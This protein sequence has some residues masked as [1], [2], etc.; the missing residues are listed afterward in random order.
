MTMPS[1]SRVAIVVL[2]AVT[3]VGTQ[4]APRAGA[5]SWWVPPLGS[6]PWQW[7]LSHPLRLSNPQDMG[8]DDKL[9]D[10]KPASP[11]VIYDIDGIINPAS[12]VAALHAEGKHVVCYI[13][14]GAAGNY[15]SAASEGV[16]TTY[17][18]QLRKA[19]VFGNKVSG[20]PEYYLDIRSSATVSIIESMI[21]QQCA[22]KGF[23]AVETDIDEEYGDN[24]GFPLKR[25]NQEQYMTTLADY[26]HG[27][28]L[29]WWIK[30]PDD[31]GSATYAT[32]MHSL[33]DAVLTEQCNQYS[34]CGFLSA[35]QGKKAVFN[36]EYHL[37]PSAFC[38]N[39][40]RLGFNGA[41]FNLNLTGVRKPCQ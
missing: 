37:K 7:E 23:D 24:S 14:V 2:F 41:R 15:Y 35:Y 30:N 4:S 5:S 21:D 8:T 1:L 16:A 11:P 3:G 10:G 13:E 28:G 26:M 20:Y 38:A 36:A 39:D 9:P 18:D 32:D 12:T 40:D 34:S 27:L 25:S 17:Y 19:N 33:A 6:Q 31:T 29:G 22:A